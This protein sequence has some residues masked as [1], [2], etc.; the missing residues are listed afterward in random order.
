[1]TTRIGIALCALM[2]ALCFTP[3]TA[4]AD[5]KLTKEDK[6]L[7]KD[8]MR[9]LEMGAQCGR[10]A[11]TNTKTD[12]VK[13][14]GEKLTV[15]HTDMIKELHAFANKHN[16]TFEGDPSNPDVHTKK[17]LED[18][19]NKEFDRRYM[20]MVVN[21]HE[22]MLKTFKQG[23]SAAPN[24]DLRKWFTKNQDEIKKHLDEARELWGKVKKD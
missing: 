22:E 18:S 3:S 15:S 8:T 24:D 19:K 13:D 7:I 20:S 12:S 5:E 4:R 14:F 17:E 11:R 2:L 9:N 23:A 10:L 21:E 1:M 6:E 16:F